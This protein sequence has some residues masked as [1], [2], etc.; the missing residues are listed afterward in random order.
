MS[1]HTKEPW[2]IRV[3][4]TCSGAWLHIYK[5]LDD[6]DE[7]A[8]FDSGT[9]YVFDHE[10]HGFDIAVTYNENPSLWKKTDDC[11][12]IY[13]NARRIVACVN[14]CEGIPTEVLESGPHRIIQRYAAAERQRDELLAAL[15]DLHKAYRMAVGLHSGQDDA[16]T[17]R[18]HNA[19]AK[20]K[21]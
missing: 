15:K 11:D 1:E 9:V 16:Y 18:S 6:G 5:E 7:L 17:V 13:A 4:S 14:A 10:K 8:L 2:Q 20:V 12:E 19:I 3:E 21:S